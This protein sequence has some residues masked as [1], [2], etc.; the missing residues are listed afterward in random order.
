MLYRVFAFALAIASAAA[1]TT[2][3]TGTVPFVPTIFPGASSQSVDPVFAY[4]GNTSLAPSWAVPSWATTSGVWTCTNAAQ[5]NTRYTP[6]VLNISVAGVYQIAVQAEKNLR[7]SLVA[8]LVNKSD[9]SVKFDPTT[10]PCGLPFIT[11]RVLGKSFSTEGG[12]SVNDFVYLAVGF[13][14]LI[15]TSSGTS[16]GM[17]AANI[18]RAAVFQSTTPP[19]LPSTTTASLTTDSL[20]TGVGTTAI[21]TTA[22]GTTAVGSTTGTTGQ[23]QPQPSVGTHYWQTV[24]N[25][26]PNPSGCSI[27][28]SG[29]SYYTS[30]KGVTYTAPVNAIVDLLIAFDWKWNN[31]NSGAASNF[32]VN[33]ALYKGSV[34]E[35]R[36]AA[37]P[38]DPAFNYLGAIR[39][40]GGSFAAAFYNVS[41]TANTTYTLI[42]SG[43]Q[44]DQTGLFG[45]FARP[46]IVRSLIQTPTYA[47]PVRQSDPTTGVCAATTS[48]SEWYS[49]VFQAQYASYLI[50][51]GYLGGSFNDFDSYSFLYKGVNNATPPVTCPVAPGGLVYYGDTGDV[52]P[53]FTATTPGSA[54]SIVVSTYST[55]RTGKSDFALYV[56]S[57]TSVT[58]DG[59]VI[60]NTG[61]TTAAATGSSSTGDVGAAS[62]VAVNALLLIA[63]VLAVMFA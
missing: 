56:F 24:S 51:T 20:S 21:G 11:P 13:Y 61:P 50:D 43:G 63:G 17:F 4:L 40:S 41:V 33:A 53:L 7:S 12:P 16:A 47:Q 1:Q 39:G 54:Y 36:I 25:D 10:N 55:G 38:C 46:T 18:W 27:Y 3:T 6:I 5:N 34:N 32:I 22:A 60:P 57:G 29:T 45:V 52:T 58:P 28:S 49:F 62:S 59:R 9:P 31:S 42:V 30:F 8:F 37:N 48:T 44:G 26:F 15:I 19:T 23:P 2:G 14:D 35:A